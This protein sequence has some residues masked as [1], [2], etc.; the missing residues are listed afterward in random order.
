MSAIHVVVRPNPTT[1]AALESLSG[2]FDVVVDGVNVTARVGQAH[3]LAVL[4]ELSTAIAALA[5]G[6]RERVSV[7]LYADQ[8]LWELGLEIDRD[9]VLITV[10]RSG[11][12]P[13]VAVHERRV[14]FAALHQAVASAV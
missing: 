14:P 13:E 7:E 4:G 1:P 9:D 6:R 5:S 8:G 11:N 3:A 2:L 12:S 10:F